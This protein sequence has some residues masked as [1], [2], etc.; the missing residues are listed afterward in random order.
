M[1]NLLHVIAEGIGWVC[2]VLWWGNALNTW[3]VLVYIGP[4]QYIGTTPTTSTPA[5]ASAPSTTTPRKA[6]QL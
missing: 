2:I 5:D 4:R 3:E 1:R 6:P